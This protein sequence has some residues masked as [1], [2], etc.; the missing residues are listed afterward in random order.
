MHEWADKIMPP[1]VL[2][3]ERPD[4]AMIFTANCC[5]VCVSTATTLPAHTGMG[6]LPKAYATGAQID[7]NVR[8]RAS[9]CG[10]GTSTQYSVYSLIGD[11]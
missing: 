7:R 1:C 2:T 3:W 4:L 11:L 8:N 6:G 5:P 10:Y 9:L